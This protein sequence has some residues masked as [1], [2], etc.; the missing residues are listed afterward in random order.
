ML[1]HGGLELVQLTKHWLVGRAGGVV[2]LVSGAILLEL[3]VS[4]R[5][6]QRLE[7]D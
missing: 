4:R 2:L 6:K 7:R 3:L 5:K 1:L